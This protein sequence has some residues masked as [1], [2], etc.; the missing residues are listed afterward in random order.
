[1]ERTI[2]CTLRKGR[3]TYRYKFKGDL[4]PTVF[5]PGETVKLT[6]RQYEKVEQNVMKVPHP[7][8]RNR[9]V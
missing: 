7:Q 6:A 5:K 9:R 8:I 3:G 2:E 1:M 4:D